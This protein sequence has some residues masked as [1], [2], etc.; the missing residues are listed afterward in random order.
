MAHVAIRSFSPAI[1][2]DNTDSIDDRQEE[3]ASKQNKHC[4]QVLFRRLGPAKK[5]NGTAHEKQVDHREPAP[6]AFPRLPHHHNLQKSKLQIACHLERRSK[7]RGSQG[8]NRYRG[9]F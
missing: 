4:Y 7:Q 6:Q 5:N 9:L 2:N 8:A 1:S 3:E